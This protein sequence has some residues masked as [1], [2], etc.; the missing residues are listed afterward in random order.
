MRWRGLRYGSA[1]FL[2]IANGAI[3]R[4]LESFILRLEIAALGTIRAVN[5]FMP[6]NAA[7]NAATGIVRSWEK[8]GLRPVYSAN[9]LRIWLV[10]RGATAC[11]SIA[12]VGKELLQIALF[13]AGVTFL[14]LEV[15][16]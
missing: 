10:G 7:L 8:G 5:L 12:I 4:T 3:H 11:D 13:A 1:P 14:Q 6:D 2:D 9:G 16:L 15:L